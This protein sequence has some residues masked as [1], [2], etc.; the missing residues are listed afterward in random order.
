MTEI[1]EEDFKIEY[2]TDEEIGK[3]LDDNGYPKYPRSTGRYALFANGVDDCSRKLWYDFLDFP[4]LKATEAQGSRVMGAGDDH[5]EA[6]INELKLSG[7]YI[8]DE[9]SG[10]YS[11][12][13]LTHPFSIR[14]DA[15][16][17]VSK[18]PETS[19]LKV[20]REKYVGI[21][22]IPVE[23]KSVNDGAWSGFHFKKW[24]NGREETIDIWGT[25]D[26]PKLSHVCQLMVNLKVLNKPYGLLL[27][28][29]RNSEERMYYWVEWNQALW[30]ALITKYVQLEVDIVA[31]REPDR[32]P[33]CA[34]IV[35]EFYQKNGAWG[36]EGDLKKG[37][38]PYPAKFCG[39]FARCFR[40]ELAKQG[41]EETKKRA[42][43][44]I[45]EFGEK[46]GK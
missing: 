4:Q 24:K 28:S 15:I 44:L 13:Q 31:K 16:I 12:P 39:H 3:F 45:K 25:K 14:T 35:L 26:K 32:H 37:E 20:F 46:T 34:K 5:H 6:I 18:M 19:A 29:N 9:W 42:E 40:N 27:Y 11:D 36:K 43:E 10:K 1:N 23:I 33:S 30:D 2:K 38:L 7:V 22:D 17:D 21:N 8:V 41:N